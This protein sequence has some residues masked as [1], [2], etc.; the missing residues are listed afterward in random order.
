MEK[1]LKKTQNNTQFKYYFEHTQLD[2][3]TQLESNINLNVI[4]N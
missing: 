4:L 3:D 1:T 2:S